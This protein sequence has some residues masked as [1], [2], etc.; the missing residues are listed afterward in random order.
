MFGRRVK[1]TRDGA[2]AAPGGIVRDDIGCGISTCDVCT[3]HTGVS[4]PLA[5]DRVVVPDTEAL[6]TFIDVLESP[7]IT[8]VLILSTVLSAVA[9]QHKGVASRV[10]RLVGDAKRRFYVFPNDR[11]RSTSVEKGPHE[12][13]LDFEFRTQRTA[14]SWLRSHNASPAGAT[15]ELAVVREDVCDRFQASGCGAA[16]FSDVIT[17]IIG[18]T[19]P[20]V[21]R[22]SSCALPSRA[23]TGGNSEYWPSDHI[24]S[25]IAAGGVLRGKLRTSEGSCFFGEIRG[26]FGAYG[27]RVMLPGRSA[28][29]RA[30]HDDIVAV[31]VDDV[32]QW[33]APNSSASRPATAGEAIKQGFTATGRVV[34]VLEKVRRPYCG[35]ID[36]ETAEEVSTLS[37]AQSVLFRP[38][39]SRIPRIRISTQQTASLR[40]KRLRVV[41][42]DWPVNSAF[43]RGHYIDVLGDIGDKDTEAQVILLE[44]D[45]PHYDF[46]EAVYDCLPKGTWRVEASEVAKR[47]DLRDIAV[48]SVDPL[49]CRDI[50]DALHFR[51]LANGNVEVGVHIADVSHF[52]H[53]GTPIDQEAQ[54]RSTSVYLVDRRINMLPQLLT[55]NL[56]SIVADEDRYAFSALWEFSPNF[57]IVN[58]WFGKSIIRSRAALYYGDAQRM[59]EDVED[60]TEVTRSLRGL[61]RLSR[62]LKARRDEAGALTLGSQEF[63]FK[64]DNDHVNPTDMVQYQTFE[65]NSMVEEWMLF[66]NVAAAR[67][68]YK[69]FPS[70]ALLR[71]HQA[72]ADRACD[73]LNAALAAR[74]LP[75]LDVSSSKSLNESL[76]RCM[77]VDDPFINKLVRILTTRCLKQ[78]QYFCSGDL[79][80]EEFMHFGLAMPIYTHFTS[81]IRRYADVIVHR[82]LAAI[83]GAGDLFSIERTSTEDVASIA[84]NINYRH[85]MAQKAGRDSQNLFTGFFLR[86]YA[87]NDIPVEDGYVVRT[88]DA[89]VFVLVPSLGQEGRVPVETVSQAYKPLDKVR[90]KLSLIREGDVLSAKLGFR[91]LEQEVEQPEKRSRGE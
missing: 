39:S 62:I 76:N 77:S 17:S 56:C 42:D 58:E 18:D 86:K 67:Q 23:G 46:S 44:N 55:E 31:L 64:I 89:F 57:D 38:K 80:F 11:F 48:A 82:Q 51:E 49:G 20:L 68:I 35:S 54:K 71:R 10:Q 41:I 83:T 24:Q 8:N 5:A 34:G 84:A 37:G 60:N 69:A 73:D 40:T 72:P 65:T 47:R 50:D 19:H 7:D 52:V 9:R 36:V 1:V 45:I 88:S 3:Q 27:E 16:K 61:M 14:M 66:A 4:G 6:L 12:S 32:S 28:V 78:A 87:E 21:D 43:P 33:R 90:V 70:H 74:H 15:F 85:E 30:V 13:D 29:N 63:K 91:I 75:L 22:L 53:E 2:T 81:P 25:A 79:S 59:I 26:Q